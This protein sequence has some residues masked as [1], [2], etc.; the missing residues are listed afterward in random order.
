MIKRF[1]IAFILLVLVGGGLI[2]FNMFRDR[3]IQEFFANMPVQ[4]ATVSTV[5]VEPGDWTPSIQAI[6]TV[7]AT[8][9]VDLTVETTGIVSEIQFDANDR[10]EQNGLLVQLDDAIQRA[11]LAAA[12]AQAALDRTNLQRAIELQRRAVGTEVNVESA[13]AAADASAAAVEKAQASLDQK[14]LRAPFAG[15]IGI[16]QVVIGQYVSPGDIITTLQDL[17]VLRVDFSVPEQELGLLKIGQPVRLSAS[18]EN[19]TFTGAI[20]GIDPKIDPASRLVNVRAEVANPEGRLTP[21]QFVEVRVELPAESDVLALPQTAVVTSLYGDYVFVVRPAQ[22]QGGEA[23]G[24]QSETSS[25]NAATPAQAQEAD[26]PAEPQHVVN[27]V[28]VKLGRRSGGRV[29]I[30]EGLS[31]GDQVVSAGQNRL[32]NGMP[33]V[34]APENGDAQGE[35]AQ[36]GA[37]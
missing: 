1:I 36:A 10:V 2:G 28:F 33:V 22:D 30:V 35:G 13:R 25:A 26:Q 18:D 23:T 21:G 29:E 9:G 34:I 19:L 5:T 4:P 17:D 24:A 31:A 11:D 14:Q 7:S 16:P 32:T 15:V 37:Q 12:E 6:G 3:A 20:R 27:Q 8:N